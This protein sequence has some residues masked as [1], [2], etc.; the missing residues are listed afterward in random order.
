M[1]SLQSLFPVLL[2]LGVIGLLAGCQPSAA[3]PATGTGG[4][5]ATSGGDVHDHA[6]HDHAAHDHPSEGPHHGH[7]IELGNEEYHAE[8]TH[9]DASDTITI[10]IL[11]GKAA[12]AVP[13]AEKEVTIN[14]VVDGKPA[15]YTLAAAPQADDPNGKSSRFELK[16]ADLHAGLEAESAK[17]RLSLS[18]DGQPFSGTI[19]HHDHGEHEHDHDDGN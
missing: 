17:G 2:N 19:E 3:P 9:D 5:A 14:L 7:L 15:Q 1:R 4:G 10:Y 16:S 8:L 13:I 6:G 11:D 12:A 18:I